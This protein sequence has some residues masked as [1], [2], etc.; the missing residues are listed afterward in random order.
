MLAPFVD[1]VA[2]I[3][4]MGLRDLHHAQRSAKLLR[5]LIESGR[6]PTEADWGE[7]FPHEGVRRLAQIHLD[8]GPGDPEVDPEATLTGSKEETSEGGRSRARPRAREQWYVLLTDIPEDGLPCERRGRVDHW[9]LG[10]MVVGVSQG[11][12]VVDFE[13]LPAAGGFRDRFL[14]LARETGRLE[15]IRGLP[16][17]A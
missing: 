15:C 16:R 1:A 14:E 3:P 13:E 4:G 6:R 9:E 17:S 5:R 12:E 11:R 8:E 10:R 7:L 2:R